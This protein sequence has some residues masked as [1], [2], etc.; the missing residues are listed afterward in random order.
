MT[1][2]PA[3][4]TDVVNQLI[5]M[6]GEEDISF[7][8]QEIRHKKTNLIIIPNQDW[9]GLG[10]GH[11]QNGVKILPPHAT[12][13]RTRTFKTRKD[14]SITLPAVVKAWQAM[15][16]Q[17]EMEQSLREEREREKAFANP[18]N[19]R[20]SLTP[21]RFGGALGKRSAQLRLENIRRAASE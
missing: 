16:K 20:Y 17:I 7:S 9:L 2:K 1:Q 18:G 4:F 6:I 15:L 19:L 14:G 10:R 13:T 11:Q 12:S 8:S 3:T 5:S 21:Q